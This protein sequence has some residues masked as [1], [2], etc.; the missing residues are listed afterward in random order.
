MT[1]KYY[2]YRTVMN[3]YEPDNRIQVKAELINGEYLPFAIWGY[4]TFRDG[5][6]IISID[7]NEDGTFSWQ[8]DDE[9][10]TA[11]TFDE[12]Y[13]KMPGFITNSDHFE[14][15]EILEL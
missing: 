9:K 5:N 7:R 8:N 3:G 4:L 2:W 12:A 10:G 1:K 14:D 13:S 6:S 11:A 15:G